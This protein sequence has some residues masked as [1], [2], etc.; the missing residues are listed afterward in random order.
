MNPSIKKVLNYLA[1]VSVA[2]YFVE[3]G[4]NL[5]GHIG[6]LTFERIVALIFTAE[7]VWQCKLERNYYKSGEFI[8]D[9]ISIVPFY[10]GFF[11][12]H[13][14]LEYVRTLR[15]LRLMKLFWNNDSFLIMREA[16]IL[17]WPSLKNV[18]F[19]LICLCL[20]SSAV[21]FQVEKETFQNI[22]NALYFSL[23][24]ASTIGFGDFSP[25]TPFGKVITILLLYGPALSVCGSFVGV[26]GSSY[27]I[28]LEKHKQK[29]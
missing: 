24:T 3:V 25:K 15:V 23:T 19:C 29:K 18:G 26:V 13:E 20:F 7:L 10:I 22:G 28:A 12:S 2:A 27:Q 16:F 11:V 4:F 21:L 8:V 17:S 1:F 6:F 5:T 9:I 14:H